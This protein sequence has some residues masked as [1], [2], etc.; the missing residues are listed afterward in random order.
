METRS[1]SRERSDRLRRETQ[2]SNRITGSRRWWA[3]GAVLLTMFFSSLD[4]TVVSTA[5][6]TIVSEL[7]GF[8]IYAWLV[9]AYMMASAVTV[10]LYGKLSDMYGRKPFFVFGLSV[11]A[12]GSILS[13]QSQTMLELILFRG[14]QGIGAGAMLTMPRATIGDIFNPRER[15]QWMGVIGAVFG[16]A[17]V[18]GPTL[19]GWITDSIGWRWI[20][21]I[22]LP[23]AALAIAGVVFALPSV[24]VEARLKLDWRGS[25]LLVVGLVPILLG[26]TWAGGRLA[27]T[28][29][30]LIG[31]FLVGLVFL[32]LFG[33]NET[34]A[35]NPILEPS[36]FRNGI[37]NTTLLIAL[38]ITMAMFGALIFLPLFVQ[39]ALEYSAASSGYILTPMMLSLVAASMVG[40]QIVTR[41]GR[42]KVLA[43]V[44]AVLLVTGLVLF[45]RMD[46]HTTWVGVVRN[47]IVF[48]LGLG[49]LLPQLN[50]VVLNVFPYRIMG[51]VSATQQFVRSLGGVIA[52]PILGTVL[53][54]SVD[55][56]LAQ[57]MPAQLR[58]AMAA[59]GVGVQQLDPQ[60]LLSA[61]AQQAIRSR[62][63][64]FGAQGDTL[65][66][67]FLDA[68]HRALAGGTR[69]LFTIALVFGLLA[70][71][72]TL[73]LREVR[74][75]RDEF[76]DESD[77][78]PAEPR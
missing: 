76:F 22:N 24:R 51:A 71:V 14:L 41:T 61:Q 16:L 11:F 35:E 56:R 28:S 64:A 8:S 27:W 17:S 55:A 30:E 75:K 20:F 60:Q 7:H 9:T 15:G 23:V 49:T 44:G 66:R 37:F 10:P 26:F 29:P 13:G 33:V 58:Q 77:A 2:A 52:A 3:L 4:Q 63:D 21:Y 19:G 38:F 5:I 72:A 57:D 6:P 12:L 32:V 50:T 42:Y 36:L 47:M 45:T 31:L 62:F 34:R 43:V 54:R 59:G 65:Y 78:K 39:G 48:G 1:T 68:V 70:L 46:L 18:I 53:A 74:L 69:E 40:G 67:Q 25:L 73:F